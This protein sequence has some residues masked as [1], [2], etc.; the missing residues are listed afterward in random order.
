M[1]AFITILNAT[2]GGKVACGVPRKLVA[3]LAYFGLF[4]MAGCSE[5]EL[6]LPG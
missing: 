1:T 2:A 6:V 5:S 4:G 3:M